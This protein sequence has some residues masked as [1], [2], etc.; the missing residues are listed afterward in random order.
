METSGP[1][2]EEAHLSGRPVVAYAQTAAVPVLVAG[3]ER[4]LPALA[5]AHTDQAAVADAEVAASRG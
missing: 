3:A 4:T 5:V 2:Q 1:D